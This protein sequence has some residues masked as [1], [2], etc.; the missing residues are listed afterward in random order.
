L[1]ENPEILKA[2]STNKIDVK[3]HTRQS[4]FEVNYEYINPE[5]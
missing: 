4:P 1:I 3:K 2:G 5:F